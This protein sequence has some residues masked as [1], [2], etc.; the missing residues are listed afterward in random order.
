MWKRWK[1]KPVE[2][3]EMNQETSKFNSNKKKT[4]NYQRIHLKRYKYSCHRPQ[5]LILKML[6]K[7][8]FI[9][10]KSVEIHEVEIISSI[11]N[12]LIKNNQNQS[13]FTNS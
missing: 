13:K 12:K 9:C 6:K 7:I 4:I 11:Q 10:F 8:E 3:N 5:K 1:R 2:E